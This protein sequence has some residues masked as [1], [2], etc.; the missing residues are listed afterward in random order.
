P[1]LAPVMIKVRGGGMGIPNSKWRSARKLGTARL[2]NDQSGVAGRNGESLVYGMRHLKAAEPRG[3][4][5][6][7]SAA[8][9]CCIL[10]TSEA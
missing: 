8:L 6:H 9:K 3:G 10:Y 4:A 1:R 5:T 7:G 2:P